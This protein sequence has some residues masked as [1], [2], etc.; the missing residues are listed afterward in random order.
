MSEKRFI[1]G[2]S[3]VAG[4]VLCFGLG[5]ATVQAQS[6]PPSTGQS[7][8]G[9]APP[10]GLNQPG[11]INS[12]PEQ[13]ATS[14]AS[15]QDKAFLR[16]ATQGSNFEIQA[17]QLALQ[18]SSSDDVKQFAQQMIQ[19]HTKLNDQMKPIASQAGVTPPTDIS[20]KDKKVYAQLQGLSGDAFDK[21]YIQDMLEDHR[22]DLKAFQTEANSG[23]LAS[24]KSAASQGATVVQE[25]LQHAQQL[26]QA[27]NVP[28][29]GL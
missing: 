23:Q 20:K 19:D 26:A 27:H 4:F 22:N 3:G 2:T 28:A 7:P 9:S 17:A 24:E 6:G 1:N 10:G 5:V 25:H 11:G 16:E 15:F 8:T 14:Q 12:L 29:N 21:A 13:N 18:K